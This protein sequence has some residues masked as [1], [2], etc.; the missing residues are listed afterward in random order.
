MINAK[1]WSSEPGECLKT[2]EGPYPAEFS[3]IYSCGFDSASRSIADGRFCGD[4][5]DIRCIVDVFGV[6]VLKGRFPD[7]CDGSH[8]KSFIPDICG[9]LAGAGD[10]DGVRSMPAVSAVVR[11]SGRTSSV[12]DPK[13]LKVMHESSGE[14]SLPSMTCAEACWTSRR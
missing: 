8:L 4:I 5:P 13:I 10:F 14:R 1:L 11:E 12:R 7:I 2:L 9:G 3:G 6:E